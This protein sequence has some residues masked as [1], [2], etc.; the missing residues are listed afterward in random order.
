MQQ[1]QN[2]DLDWRRYLEELAHR[3]V[4]GESQLG[5]TVSVWNQ[6]RETIADFPSPRASTLDGVLLVFW[7]RGDHHFSL[8][9]DPSG[10]VEWAYSNRRT[11]QYDGGDFNVIPQLPVAAEAYMN[12][13]T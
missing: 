1:C 8:E 11:G 12:H 2:D 6:I 13:L 9:F 7:D 3:G 10:S 4:I 5:V